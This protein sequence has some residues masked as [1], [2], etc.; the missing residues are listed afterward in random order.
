MMMLL[1]YGYK[2]YVISTIVDCS[3]FLLCTSGYKAYVIST[4]VDVRYGDSLDVLGYK[5][6]VILLL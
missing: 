2:A 4:I 6:Y 3:C 1:L 5:A